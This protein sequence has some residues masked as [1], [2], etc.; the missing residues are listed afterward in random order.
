MTCGVGCLD[1]GV[2][3]LEGTYTAGSDA[4]NAVVS[5][6]CILIP[7]T[8]AANGFSVTFTLDEK[9]Y[10]WTSAD[11]VTLE[12]GTAYNL[13][14]TVGTVTKARSATSAAADGNATVVGILSTSQTWNK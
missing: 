3:S 12:R 5:Y 9:S 13:E 1:D 4:G 10:T 8:V 6:E 11:A 14:L 7:Q 2:T